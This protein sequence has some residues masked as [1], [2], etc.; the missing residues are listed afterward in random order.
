MPSRVSFLFALTTDP[1]D[2]GSAS[3]HSAGWSESWWR[4]GITTSSEPAIRELGQARA[5]MLPLE[6]SIIGFR[7]GVY[8]LSGNKIIPSG[9]STG[10]LSFAGVSGAFTDLPQV[11]LEMSGKTGGGANVSRF[12]LR[13]IPDSIMLKGEYQPN[14]NFKGTL[15]R[16]TNKLISGNWNFLG[17]D[18]GQPVAQVLSIAAGVMTTDGGLGVAVGDFVRLLRVF[19]GYGESVQGAYRVTVVGAGNTY[20]LAGFDPAIVVLNSG[21][22]RKDVVA[23]FPFSEVE[24]SRATIRKVGRPFESYRGRRSKR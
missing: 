17:R 12:T 15:T 1:D 19:D 3:P 23:L 24:P 16:F 5:R 10:K 22:A 8:T 2:R 9:S 18:L 13:G 6:A 21:S 20:T 7:I 11:A 14:V 4:T